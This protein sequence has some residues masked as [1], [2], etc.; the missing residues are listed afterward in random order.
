MRMIREKFSIYLAEQARRRSIGEVIRR[1]E[2]LEYRSCGKFW[3]M[4][5]YCKNFLKS[6]EKFVGL[7]LKTKKVGNMMILAFLHLRKVVLFKFFNDST[8]HLNL[9]CNNYAVSNRGKARNVP[10]FLTRNLT[11][12][13]S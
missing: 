10:T 6:Q 13:S 8:V 9:I 4:H 3:V 7:F 2:L 5:N 1:S 12:F 11:D